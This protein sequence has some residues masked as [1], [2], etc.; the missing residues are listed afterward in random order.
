MMS[1]TRP[2]DLPS[3]SWP[4]LAANA[5]VF[6][7]LWFS[8]VLGHVGLAVLCVLL[9]LI[10]GLQQGWLRARWPQLLAIAALGMAADAGLTLMGAYSFPQIQGVWP[11][12]AWL[13]CLWLGFVTTLPASLA[14]L[15][16]KPAVAVAAFAVAGP[17][18]YAAGRA[19][20]ALQFDNPVLLATAFL[21]ACVGGMATYCLRT[22]AAS[23]SA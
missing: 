8:A 10:Q 21:W 23:G 5:L 20:G 1:L 2:R 12:P 9:L 7:G 16:R 11:L 13:M 14:W 3:P 15:L 22:P 17:L 6:Q 18:S 19:L 4:H